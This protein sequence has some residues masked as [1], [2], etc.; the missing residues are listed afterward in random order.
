MVDED[1]KV[2]LIEV[3]ARPALL[4][5]K[6]DKAVNRPMVRFNTVRTVKKGRRLEDKP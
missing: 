2:H 1:L 6:L 5:D 4:D 3:N